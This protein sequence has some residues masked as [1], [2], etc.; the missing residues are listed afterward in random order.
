MARKSAKVNDHMRSEVDL[1][2]TAY[3]YRQR[4]R[5]TMAAENGDAPQQTQWGPTPPISWKEPTKSEEKLTE[6]LVKCLE[7]HDMYETDEE[8]KLRE[9]VLI[10]LNNLF[11]EFVRK[12]IV[13]QGGLESH[14][15]EAGGKIFT[16]GSYRLGVHGRNSDIDTLCVAPKQVSREDFFREM[17]EMLAKIPEITE[18]APIPDAFVPMIGLKFSGIAIDFLYAQLN[19]TT[20]PD[21]LELFDDKLLDGLDDR[22]IRSLNGSRVTDLILTLVP[23]VQT[24]R[25]ALRC[26]KLWAKQ[27]AVYAN[28]LGFLGGVAWAIAVARVCQL[29]P[30]ATASHVVSQFFN[31]MYRWQWPSPVFLKQ[32]EDSKSATIRVWNP[33]IYNQDKA[34]RMPIITPAYPSMCSTHNVTASTQEVTLEEMGRGAEYVKKLLEKAESS[35]SSIVQ[36]NKEDISTNIW[37]GLFE[38]SDFFLKYKYYIVVVASSDSEARQLK[39]QGLVEARLR[40]LVM[41]L[42]LVDN[43][44]RAHPYIKGQEKINW[45]LGDDEK[46]RAAHGFPPPKRDLATFGIETT[47][48]GK[49]IVKPEEESEAKK[50]DGE[51]EGEEKENEEKKESTDEDQKKKEEEEEEEEVD[52]SIPA[53]IFSTTFY[54]GLMFTDPVKKA[55]REAAEATERGDQVAA[56]AA[57]AR[58][59]QPGGKLKIDVTWP[60]QA[61]VSVVKEW[62][63]YDPEHMGIVVSYQKGSKLPVELTNSQTTAGVKRKRI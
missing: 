35:P 47:E 26:I 43:V 54:I 50:E 36:S 29:F 51:G 28:V 48:D 45:C 8:N 39:W 42:E 60:T 58:A 57:T 44:E 31:L 30:N 33:K 9:R 61:Y 6:E 7:A 38:K 4:R 49:P 3:T 2:L 19:R 1:R 53:P 25:T 11:K 41:K 22:D 5:A 63:G 23:N 34:H 27:R 13:E 56:A 18:I 17:P 10:R 24:F 52:D 15:R 14:A 21:D 40:Q 59:Q 32:I 12:V 37:E 46:F 20:V 62:D 55:Q 16:F